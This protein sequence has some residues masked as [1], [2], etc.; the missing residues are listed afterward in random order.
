MAWRAIDGTGL[1][2]ISELDIDELRAGG[3]PIG[4]QT[5]LNE[6][7]IAGPVLADISAR[8]SPTGQRRLG[9]FWT[10]TDGTGT[11]NAAA[12]VSLSS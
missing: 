1:L 12:V 5:V 7:S 2:C 11:L 10:G 8:N 4:T 9:M 3:D 6:R